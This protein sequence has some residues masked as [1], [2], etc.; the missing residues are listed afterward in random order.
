MIGQSLRRL[1]DA[2]FLTGSGCYLDD[3][4]LPGMLHA[5]IVRSPHAHADIKGI[6]TSAARAA[7][8]V[9]HQPA[10]AAS[11]LPRPPTPAATS[12]VLSG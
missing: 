1:E 2:R 4:T 5:A 3:I 11:A 12:G 8:G 6:D 9:R 7:P 10:G